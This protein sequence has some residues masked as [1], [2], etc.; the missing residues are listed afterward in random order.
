MLA[1]KSPQNQ[2]K[3]K[4]VVLSA[5]V[6]RSNGATYQPAPPSTH[7]GSVLTQPNKTGAPRLALTG[8][9][10]IMRAVGRNIRRDRVANILTRLSGEVPR[11]RR[12]WFA[13]PGSGVS[14]ELRKFEVSDLA[15]LAPAQRSSVLQSSPTNQ[16]DLASEISPLAK[17]C[18]QKQDHVP[19]SG[20]QPITEKGAVAD[21]PFPHHWSVDTPEPNP[22]SEQPTSPSRALTFC[23]LLRQINPASSLPCTPP[24][25]PRERP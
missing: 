21:P 8:I 13:Q 12:L 25:S 4:F 2:Q 24:I 22:H 14:G 6:S 18:L 23:R 16:H 15:R 17:V 5:R 10:R 19:A 11:G 20:H 7:R 3:S 9:G 1:F